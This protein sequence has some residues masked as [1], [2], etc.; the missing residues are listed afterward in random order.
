LCGRAGPGFEG[1][2]SLVLLLFFVPFSFLIGQNA[3]PEDPNSY[4]L[5]KRRHNRLDF[6]TLF[7]KIV[8]LVRHFIRRGRCMFS[9]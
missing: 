9:G 3:F 8:V 7:V 2:L 6:F 1:F 5:M 4:E